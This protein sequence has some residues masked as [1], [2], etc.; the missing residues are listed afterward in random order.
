MPTLATA[1]AASPPQVRPWRIAVRTPGAASA[2]AAL[3]LCGLLP[4]A[5]AGAWL[6]SGAWNSGATT[7][8]AGA[9]RA[10][11]AKRKVS[12][13]RAAAT[14]LATLT[15]SFSPDRPG[16]STT[17]GFGFHIT[18]TAGLAPPPLTSIDLHMPAGMNYTATTLGLATCM[19]KT[20]EEKGISGCPANS[21]LGYGNAFVEVPF[22]TGS[23]REF[24]EVQAV[25]GPSQHGNMVVLF[26]ANGQTP[27]YAQLVFE[28]VVLPDSGP[29]GSQLST[30]VPPIH[31]VPGGPDVSVVAVNATIGPSHLTYY[32]TVHGRHVAFHPI[33]IAV[34]ERCP[35][36]GF[37]FS[38]AFGFQD[39]SATTASTRVPCPRRHH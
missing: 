11:A 22:G 28:G 9:V 12:A 16:A 8:T 36:G 35:H 31:S 10:V 19:P 15:A 4:A 3:L 7:R 27:V 34:P 6:P 14:E 37:M 26:Y 32:K 33:G 17:I 24:P 1:A 13:V 39:G 29:F 21:R 25:A 5:A 2:L 23:G 18:T 38:A 30:V 20:L